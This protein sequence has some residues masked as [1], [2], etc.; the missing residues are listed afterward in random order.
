MNSIIY[1]GDKPKVY[2]FINNIDKKS[3]LS[4]VISSKI[5]TFVTDK[6]KLLKHYVE[7]S[8]WHT[9]F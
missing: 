5:F 8:T 1:R 6:P 4:F 2:I 3:A 9:E 7:L